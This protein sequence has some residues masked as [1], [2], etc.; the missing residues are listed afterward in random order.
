MGNMITHKITLIIAPCITLSHIKLMNVVHTLKHT[1][2][3]Y[4]TQTYS[5]HLP[6]SNTKYT[7]T[8]FKHTVHAYHT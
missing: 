2:H 7:L 6:H 5:A 8:T 4:H 1:V 3:T